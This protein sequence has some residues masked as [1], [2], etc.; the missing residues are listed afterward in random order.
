MKRRNRFVARTVAVLAMAAVL[1]ATPAPAVAAQPPPVVTRD[2]AL[3]SVTV[4]PGGL[5]ASVV[6]NQFRYCAIICPLVIE[7]A[8]TAAVTSVQAPGAFLTALRSGDLWRAFGVA[9]ASVTGPTNTA[10]QAAILADGAKVA[11]RALNALQVGVVGLLN[12]L[13][14]AADGLPGV[15]RALKVAR[16]D[17]FSALNAPIVAN[18][19][20][21]VRPRGV[22]QVAVVEAINVGAAVAFPAFNHMLS[23]VFETP[24]A[25][26]RELAATGDP[27]RAIAAGV[28]VL[29]G[30]LVAAGTVI[31]ESVDTALRN[32]GAAVEQSHADGRA[33][34]AS[35]DESPQNADAEQVAVDPDADAT[36]APDADVTAAPDDAETPEPVRHEPSDH[37]A[38]RSHGDDPDADSASVEP[39]EAGTDPANSSGSAPDVTRDEPRRGSSSEPTPGDS[40]AADTTG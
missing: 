23:A 38:A 7:A 27:V 5:L 24:D 1:A 39:A 11:P 28:R 17:T 19:T 35:D 16:Q 31:A 4:P 14:A 6:V 29:A 34:P 18:P 36:E 20:P 8:V 12:V 3:T 40:A 15:V 9:S 21:T 32:I 33:R 26:A 25:F 22:L 2:V 37:P 30:R 10:A 13:P